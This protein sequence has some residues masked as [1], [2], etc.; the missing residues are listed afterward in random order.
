V[1]LKSFCEYITVVRSGIVRVVWW[2]SA[3]AVHLHRWRRHPIR[4]FAKLA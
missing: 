4:N 3:T 2:N 1:N